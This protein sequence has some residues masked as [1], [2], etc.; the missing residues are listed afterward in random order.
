MDVV[1]GRGIHFL[2]IDAV[3]DTKEVIA[4]GTQQRVKFFAKGGGQYFLGV[5]LANGGDGIGKKD[6]APHDIDHV[7]QFHDLRIEESRGGAP[8]HF[9]DTVTKD[10]LVGQVM[11]GVDGGG[12][13]EERVIV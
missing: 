7:C 13:G 11:D 1:V 12:V 5:A 6:A 2:V 8:R 4:P 10:A 3:E 9:E